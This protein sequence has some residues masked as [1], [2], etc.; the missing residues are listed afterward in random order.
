MAVLTKL[1]IPIVISKTMAGRAA[2]AA[3][4]AATRG[5]IEHSRDS[6]GSEG[7]EDSGNSRVYTSCYVNTTS[8][9]VFWVSVGYQVFPQPHEPAYSFTLDFRITSAREV[10]FFVKTPV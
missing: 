9:K 6:K 4:R 1:P 5:S 3:T 7:N 2:R 10:D 8:M